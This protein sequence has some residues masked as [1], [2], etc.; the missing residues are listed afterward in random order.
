MRFFSFATLIVGVQFTSDATASQRQSA[1]DLISGR[2]IGGHRA[3]GIYLVRVEDPGDGSS[4][5]RAVERLEALPF[6][7]GATPDLATTPND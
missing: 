1:I 7:A 2:F 5:M 6:V 3:A 4:I